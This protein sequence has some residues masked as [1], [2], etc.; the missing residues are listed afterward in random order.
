MEEE[1]PSRQALATFYA[2]YPDDI[3]KKDQSTA[4][5]YE[6][7]ELLYD[8]VKVLYDATLFTEGDNATLD[9]V[10]PIMEFV[11]DLFEK[12][13]GKYSDHAKISPP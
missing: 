10:L 6:L 9:R 7:P 1:S 2:K 5:N 13:M 11:M 12:G 3:N 8:F 4:R